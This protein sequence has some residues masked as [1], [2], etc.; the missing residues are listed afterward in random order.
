[1]QNKEIKTQE[2][3]FNREIGVFGGVSIVGGVMIGSGIF[4]LGSYVL[5]RVNMNLGLAL[6]CWIIGGIISLMG[7]L[8]YAE[9][10]T[11]MPKAGGKTVYLNEAYHPIVGFLAG[12]SDWA[13]AGPGSIASIAIALATATKTFIP[14]ESNSIKIVAIVVIIILT[15]YNCYGIKG[16]SIVQNISM[17]A[18]LIPIALIMI[19]AIFYGNITPDLSFSAI[20]E[21]IVTSDKSLFKMIPLGV[22]A[23][24]W[25]YEGWT[26]LN[27]LTEEIKNPQKN[28]P[29]SLIIGIAGVMVIYVLFNFSLFRV[30]SIEDMQNMIA[31]EN[32]YLGTEVAKRILGQAG[33]IVVV[34]GMVLAMFSA[35]NALIIAQP[36]MYYAMAEEGHFF[37]VYSYLHPKYKVPTYA[38]IIQGIISIILVMLRN[39]EQLTVLVVF[40]GMIFNLL[41]LIAVIICRKKFPNEPRPYK[42]WLYPISVIFTSLIFLGL[43]VNNF[44]EDTKN[45]LLGFGIILIGI[46]FYQYFDKKLKQEKSSTK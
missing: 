21:G 24:L 34:V 33:A 1:M 38:I 30:I 5:Q 39:L 10:G 32:F 42:V 4:Y 11:L 25:A 35:L 29:L 18:K 19:L 41:S 14:M 46:I 45:S 8:C 22:V 28:L 43:V 16:A 44:I 13:I 31:S 27:S 6:I 40:V 15:I 26:N 7:G 37:K 17:I 9:L 2:T 3:K 20:H 36:R 23:T 12:F